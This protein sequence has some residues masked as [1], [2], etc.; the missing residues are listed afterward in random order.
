MDGFTLEVLV[1]SKLRDKKYEPS[2]KLQ[3]KRLF[4]KYFIG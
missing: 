2:R 3:I 1:L 4:F